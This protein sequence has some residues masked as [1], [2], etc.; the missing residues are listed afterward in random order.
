MVDFLDFL[1]YWDLFHFITLSE[2]EG[3][4]DFK[5]ARVFLLAVTG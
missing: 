3:R 4:S 2:P 5:T 1:N